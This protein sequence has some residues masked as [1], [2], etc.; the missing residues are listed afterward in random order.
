MQTAADYL[1]IDVA[2]VRGALREGKSLADLAED[3]G[4]SVDGLKRVLRDAI[5]EDAERAVDDG[6]LTKTRAERLVEKLGNGV[7]RRVRRL[8]APR[9]DDPQTGSAT[10]VRA[11]AR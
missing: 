4:K 1:G 3:E 5:G 6:V 8:P 7:D 11:R 2:D 9:G 10:A